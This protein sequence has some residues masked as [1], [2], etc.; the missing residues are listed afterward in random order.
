MTYAKELTGQNPL[1]NRLAVCVDDFHGRLSIELDKTVFR[2]ILG[3]YPELEYYFRQ[4]RKIMLMFVNCIS[5]K[6]SSG[7]L[8][9]PV[10]LTQ[11]SRL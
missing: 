11:L 8:K 2:Q 4:N 6:A 5:T 7:I 10:S 9:Y 1:E 3:S